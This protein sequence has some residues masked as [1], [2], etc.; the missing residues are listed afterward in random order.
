MA[1]LRGEANMKRTILMIMAVVFAFCLTACG[2]SMNGMKQPA[3]L[4]KPVNCVKQLRAK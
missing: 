4:P 1:L 3:Q 2:V